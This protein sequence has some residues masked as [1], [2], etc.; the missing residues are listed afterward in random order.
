[1]VNTST[2]YRLYTTVTKSVA[3]KLAVYHKMLET[4][5]Q[6]VSL[7][8]KVA[9]RNSMTLG[10]RGPVSDSTSR[11]RSFKQKQAPGKATGTES[12]SSPW[13]AWACPQVREEW[14][15]LVLGRPDAEMK[16]FHSV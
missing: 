14:K 4:A 11:H 3:N 10:L 7:T 13:L 16:G 1:M 6:R 5:E 15:G 12:V 2:V 9:V 8:H